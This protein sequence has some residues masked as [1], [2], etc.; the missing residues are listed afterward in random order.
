MYSV[1]ELQE[2][3]K[4][5]FRSVYKGTIKISKWCVLCHLPNL[6]VEFK[7]SMCNSH[8]YGR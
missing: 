7:L 2:R 3:Y 1:L 6:V 8:A 5:E 4:F